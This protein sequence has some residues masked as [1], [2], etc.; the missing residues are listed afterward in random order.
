MISIRFLLAGVRGRGVY[1][2]LVI[3]TPT[4]PREVRKIEYTQW[5]NSEDLTLSVIASYQ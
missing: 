2:V 5:R 4:R 1:Y 3:A